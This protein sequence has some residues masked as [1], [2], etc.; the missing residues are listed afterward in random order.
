MHSCYW[1]ERAGCCGELVLWTQQF[2][3]ER[4]LAAAFSRD[5]VGVVGVVQ[6]CSRWSKQRYLF[7]SSTCTWSSPAPIVVVV[8][9]DTVDI[10]GLPR[11]LS[12]NQRP[13]FQ[14]LM[15]CIG[16]SD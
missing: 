2:F 3:C 13:L 10:G 11:S 4:A 1:N 16:V 9:V 15:I 8:V 14:K 12:S 7:D 5:G 6:C